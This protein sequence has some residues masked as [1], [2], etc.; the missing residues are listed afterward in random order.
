MVWLQSGDDKYSVATSSTD[1]DSYAPALPEALQA[2]RLLRD[3]TA[4][5]LAA[6]GFHAGRVPSR[7]P[8][9]AFLP[10]IPNTSPMLNPLQ[11]QEGTSRPR[12]AAAR[13]VARKVRRRA[14]SVQFDAASVVS[15]VYGAGDGDDALSTAD[16]LDS[17]LLELQRR[18]TTAR[19]ML[20]QS[21]GRGLSAAAHARL[22]HHPRTTQA[23]ADGAFEEPDLGLEGSGEASD[24]LD[25]LA[26]AGSRM[27]EA[28]VG[29]GD[30]G[31]GVLDNSSSS[32]SSK[33][34]NGTVWAPPATVVPVVHEAGV[35]QL[36]PGPA[37]VPPQ[38]RVPAAF[39]TQLRAGA[40]A[41]TK[42]HTELAPGHGGDAS[43]SSL[44]DGVSSLFHA[45]APRPVP[46]YDRAP[47]QPWGV[48]EFLPRQGSV[49]PMQ[50]QDAAVR[51][52][53]HQYQQHQQLSSLLSYHDGSTLEWPTLH[54]SQHV[55]GAGGAA[56]EE[57]D[58]EAEHSAFVRS[59]GGRSVHVS[60]T[61]DEVSVHWE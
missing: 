5:E 49:V 58:M 47:A 38:V 35:G 31:E 20:A 8:R 39:S 15:L 11:H 51:D 2:S 28:V 26:W 25:H 42:R 57:Y 14:G 17:V 30:G 7:L 10:T 22:Q 16:S 1:A 44:H 3:D 60:R 52:S 12:A 9:P 24:P 33:L 27:D 43:A 50:Q 4:A 37:A 46:Q 59:A 45:A 32:S 21:H 40:G 23:V 36:A 53:Q 6:V 54:E 56:L 13:Q 29:T 61:G 55:F 41:V 48:S 19:T 34:A 18:S